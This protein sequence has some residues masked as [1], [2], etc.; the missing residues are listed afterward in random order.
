[1]TCKSLKNSSRVMSPTKVIFLA[2][3][4][5]CQLPFFS[6]KYWQRLTIRDVYE[7]YQI[8]NTE[9]YIFH[10]KK[11]CLQSHLNAQMKMLT[12]ET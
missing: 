8:S 6:T 12:I 4:P 2:L 10:R 3:I 9:N 11:K 5:F 7:S 1:M